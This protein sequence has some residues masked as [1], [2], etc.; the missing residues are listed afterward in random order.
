MSVKIVMGNKNMDLSENELKGLIKCYD[1]TMAD[2]GTGDG[3]FVYKS[4][5]RDPNNFYVGIDPSEKQLQIYS[6]K[7]LKK[8]LPNVI[9]CL[10]S[11]EMLPNELSGKVDELTIILPWGTLLQNIVLPSEEIC[12]TLG[13]LL[14]TGGEI[15]IVL[16]YH[17]DLEPAEVGRLEL[18]D[19][20]TSYVEHNIVPAF[21]KSGFELVSLEKLEKRSLKKL[22]TTW[23]KKLSF[24]KMREIFKLTLTK[25]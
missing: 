15:E 6:K 17:Q 11:L 1:K 19:L 18:P 16:G 24:G 12:K 2:L 14:K 25:Q 7:A 5:L 4:A 20:S 10:S 13:G 23:S 22:E 8:K 9:F 21:K 3:R